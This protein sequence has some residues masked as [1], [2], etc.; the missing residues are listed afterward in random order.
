[1]TT[2]LAAGALATLAL[3]AAAAE[4]EPAYWQRLVHDGYA[5]EVVADAG[6]GYDVYV[7][8]GEELAARLSGTPKGMLVAGTLT[9]FD[10]DD[11]FEVTLLFQDTERAQPRVRSYEWTGVALELMAVRPPAPEQERVQNGRYRIEHDVLLW[12]A[13]PEGAGGGN[14]TPATYRYDFARGAWL[15]AERGWLDRLPFIGE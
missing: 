2:R 6:G 5:V 15:P 10:G 3:S 9:D 8:R 7:Y 4:V 1:M 13:A 12:E 14:K 11:A